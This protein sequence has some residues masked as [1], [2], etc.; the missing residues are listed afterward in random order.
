MAK[1]PNPLV[2]VSYMHADRPIVEKLVHSL[3]ANGVEVWWDIDCLGPGEIWEDRIRDTIAKGDAFV[4]CFSKAYSDRESTQMKVELDVATNEMRKFKGTRAWFIPVQFDDAEIPPLDIGFG[5]TL[6]DLQYVRIGND[7]SDGVSRILS[8][9]GM[10]D[11]SSY[12]T[13]AL[14]ETVTAGMVEQMS[15]G[16]LRSMDAAMVAADEISSGFRSMLHLR[17]FARLGAGYPVDTWP[18][19]AEYLAR[20]LNEFRLWVR[21]CNLGMERILVHEL[22]HCN[23]LCI[24][25][26]SRAILT[27]I[28]SM[29]E[30]ASDYSITLVDRKHATLKRSEIQEFAAQLR[31]FGFKVRPPLTLDQWLKYL[32]GIHHRSEKCDAILFGAEAVLADGSVLFPQKIEEREQLELRALALAHA[33]RYLDTRILCIAESY[34]FMSPLADEDARQLCAV[35]NFVSLGPELFN[36]Y[37]CEHGTFATDVMREIRRSTDEVEETCRGKMLAQYPAGSRMVPFSLVP[38]RRLRNV[39]AFVADVDDTLTV[40]GKMTTVSLAALESL[41]ELELRVM[42]ITGRSGAWA[43]A[44]LS[45]LPAVSAVIAE[46]GGAIVYSGERIELTTDFDKAALD[47]AADDLSRKF[48][49]SPSPDS[50]FR[51]TDR[52]LLRPSHA[53]EQ[54]LEEMARELDGAFELVTSSIHIHVKPKGVT[55]ATGLERAVAKLGCGPIDRVLALGDSPNDKP[56]FQSEALSVGVANVRRYLGELND[57]LPAFVTRA[58]EADGFAEVTKRLCEV[59]PRV[60]RA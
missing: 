34:K 42:L 13:G 22:A 50:V 44:L 53:S 2:F 19:S 55:K 39:S 48:G 60:A 45:Y 41:A 9:L 47:R 21:A 7:F 10:T 54:V 52:T 17:H 25:E 37:V 43:Q 30:N 12:S 23:H 11:R 6:R 15:A 26:Y 27:G 57:G 31:D 20:Y 14:I 5:K 40:R 35:S 4:A 18:S 8:A 58:S 46:N 3:R 38:T 56:L 28:S 36:G 33:H 24:T 1:S 32:D 59:L 49:L 51:L 16:K 29:K